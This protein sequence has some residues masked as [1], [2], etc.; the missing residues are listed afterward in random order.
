M[1]AE[2]THRGVSEKKARE[3]LTNL[4]PGQEVIDQLEYVD[5]LIANDHRGRLE[6][7]P[8]LYV[9]YVRDNVAVPRLFLSSR[10]V[11][12]H[13]EAHQG[14]NEKVALQAQLELEYDDYRTAQ[15]DHHIEAMPRDE[16]Q[17]LHAEQ[18][19]LI[20]IMCKSMT[21]SQI[22]ELTGRAVRSEIANRGAV[23]LMQFDDYVA[24]KQG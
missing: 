19:R 11:R 10:K 13:Q 4:K 21:P 9:F 8:G 7:P 17:R 12:L 22:E 2:L 18:K 16:Y 23:K 24:S 1:F 15:I 14:R 3:L 6:N 5:S 20:Q